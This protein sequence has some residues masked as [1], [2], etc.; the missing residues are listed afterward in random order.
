MNF[1]LF[2][3]IGEIGFFPFLLLA[4]L[5]IF[6]NPEKVAMK[7]RWLSKPIKPNVEVEKPTLKK[8]VPMLLALYLTFHLVFPFRH[9]LYEGHVDWNGFG[10]RFAWRMKIMYKDVDMH[11]Y[12]VESG[13]T[14]KREVNLGHFLNDK[15]YTNLMYYPDF[16]PPVAQHIRKEGIKAGM[17]NPKVVADFNVGFNGEPK[18]PLVDPSV[19][20]SRVKYESGTA[21]YWLKSGI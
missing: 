6:M 21:V 12:L 2:H 8:W 1:W 11:F 9:F 13:S 7:L 18:R 16:I 5:P 14:V 10:Q 17:K 20:L 3:D 4:C 19:D 15:Q